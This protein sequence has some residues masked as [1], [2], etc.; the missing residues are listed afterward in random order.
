MK[1]LN[2][3]ELAALLLTLTTSCLAH[4]GHEQIP[5]PEGA[6]WATRHMAGQLPSP[7]P[8]LLPR[9]TNPPTEEHYLN[10]FDAATF[11]TLHDYDNTGHWS[12]SD[13]RRT[14]GLS[15][16]STKD[17]PESRKA[18]VVDRVLALYDNDRSGSISFAEF[19]VGHAR[20]IVLPDFGLGPGHHGD[21]EYEY[22]IHH[23]EKYH[24][25]DTTEE[26]LTHPEDIEHFEKHDREEAEREA[27][28]RRDRAG[29]IVEENI[30]LKFRRG[31]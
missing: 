15:D 19:T 29:G 11:F 9:N 30:P 6:D 14:Y 12:P 8:P 5:I 20:G 26:E 10:S 2:P 7:L 4:G 17:I 25:D 1:S 31:G 23:W 27:L 18:E 22:E 24:G 16:P 13:I 3:L 28:E 21:D